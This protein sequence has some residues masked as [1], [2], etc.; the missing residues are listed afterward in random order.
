MG[1][2]DKG[3]CYIINS[4]EYWARVWLYEDSKLNKS[5]LGY[6]VSE[7]IYKM[8]NSQQKEKLIT[9]FKK[10]FL[11][12]FDDKK[13]FKPKNVDFKMLYED[14]LTFITENKRRSLGD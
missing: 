10:R 9:A 7:N 12:F 1:K 3:N 8:L 2:T 14:Y 5:L 11:S 4:N 13:A 6:Y